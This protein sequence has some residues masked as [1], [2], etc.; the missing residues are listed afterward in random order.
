MPSL[1]SRQSKV[2]TKEILDEQ[3]ISKRPKQLE[4]DFFCAEQGPQVFMM[5]AN[6]SSGRAL[7]EGSDCLPKIDFS[8]LC[9][10]S[11]FFVDSNWVEDEEMIS[12][13]DVSYFICMNF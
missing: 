1:D 9:P 11:N 7:C 10:Q 6:L 4:M 2:C 8:V 5:S 3:F 13:K 12:D